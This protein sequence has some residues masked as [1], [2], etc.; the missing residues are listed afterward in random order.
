MNMETLRDTVEHFQQLDD[1][2]NLRTAEG[3]KSIEKQHSKGKLHARERI[4]LLLD[5]GTF[6]EI[7][8][9]VEHRCNNFGMEKKRQSGDGIVTGFGKICGKQVYVYADDFTFL[10]G[11]LGEMQSAKICKVMDL[12]LSCGAPVIGI[13]DSGGG[14][15][16]EGVDAKHGYGEIFYR[17]SIMSGVVPQISVIVGP[18]AGGAVYSPALTDFIFTVDKLTNMYVTGPRVIKVALGEDVTAEQLG[19][20]RVQ[21]T[22]NGVAHFMAQNE[23]ECYESVRQLMSYIP[24]N[25]KEHATTY[26]CNDELYR[27]NDALLDYVPLSGKKGYDMHVVI[28]EIADKDSF[29]ETQASFAKNMITGF[30]R[31]A[32]E[33]VGVIA[34]Q[35]F[36][37]AGCIDIN[38]SVKS[39]RFIR[40]CDAF[41]IPILTLVDVP[42]FLPGTNQE[43]GGIIRHGAKMLYAYSEATVPK[44]TLLLRKAYGGA[45]N[46]MCSKELRSDIYMS[47]P[48]GE[49]AVMGAEEASKIIYKKELEASDNPEE[50]KRQKIEEYQENFSNPYAAARRGYLDRIIDPVNSRIEIVNAFEALKN[51]DQ[52]LPWKKHCNIPL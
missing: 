38:A 51:K 15:I 14:R 19:G 37:L 31:I 32:G 6:T 5:A 48:S 50:L 29:M 2:I 30:C 13:R 10:G 47:W 16:Q 39:A 49:I 52:K 28:A 27:K 4:E 1:N 7:D 26:T 46:A 40:F 3:V 12:A 34:N 17:N 44:V 20:A 45:H 21:N 42:G 41:S 18:C 22:T 24:S 43:Y 8:A 36:F 35:P 11:A 23:H 9:F 33:T 25:N